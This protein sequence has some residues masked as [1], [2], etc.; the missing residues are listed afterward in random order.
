[1]WNLTSESK[2]DH[3]PP[4]T[5]FPSTYFVE[6][7]LLPSTYFFPYWRNMLVSVF[8]CRAAE[9]PPLLVTIQPVF[10][11]K[12]E[13]KYNFQANRVIYWLLQ[14]MAIMKLQRWIPSVSHAITTCHFPPSH[15]ID[16]LCVTL[17]WVQQ[18]KWT[19]L[20]VVTFR[21]LVSQKLQRCERCA[22]CAHCCLVSVHQ[23]RPRIQKKW[24]QFKPE[25]PLLHFQKVK[26]KR[27]H[28]IAFEI[29]V[30]WG[31]ERVRGGDTP[32]Y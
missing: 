29:K 6:V 1:M 16:E 13:T 18:M 32:M 21:Y 20:V 10:L 24:I 7:T 5:L 14:C 17:A 12:M 28:Q 25:W 3:L 30:W 27:F 19:I 9:E 8:G 11:S 26:A 22:H 4:T 31:S 23:T 2:S 15:Y